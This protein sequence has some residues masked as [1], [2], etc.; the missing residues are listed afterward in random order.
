MVIPA[1]EP[2]PSEGGTEAQ[3]CPSSCRVVDKAGEAGAE[4]LVLEVQAGQPLGFRGADEVWCGRLGKRQVVLGVGVAGVSDIQ[5]AP[6]AQLVDGVLADSLEKPVAPSPGTG[7]ACTRLLSTNE[8]TRPTTSA[9]LTSPPAQTA[10]AASRSRP[11]G[12]T[13]SRH[14]TARSRSPIRL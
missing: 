14:S 4:V 10:R 2:E 13:E 7:S 1:D 8:P 9:A 11:V 6:L 5:L 12:K 3:R